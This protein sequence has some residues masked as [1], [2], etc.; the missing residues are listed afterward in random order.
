LRR[1]DL[2]GG[3]FF[4]FVLRLFSQFR[5]I[6][7]LRLLLL[8]EAGSTFL[9]DLLGPASVFLSLGSFRLGLG[10]GLLRFS[11]RLDSRSFGLRFL[12]FGLLGRRG[13]GRLCLCLL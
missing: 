3:E 2:D 5:R 1:L 12:L 11:L 9:R 6:G 7:L 10:L 13:R 4:L 8:F